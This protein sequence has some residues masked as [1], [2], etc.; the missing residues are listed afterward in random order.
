MSRWCCEKGM[1]GNGN[2]EVARKGQS[3]LLLQL[4]RFNCRTSATSLHHGLCSSM[5]RLPVTCS[6]IWSD[7]LD[8]EVVFDH[9]A[10]H[11]AAVTS[12]VVLE[13]AMEIDLAEQV[14]EQTVVEA[15]LGSMMEFAKGSNT[16]LRM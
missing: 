9:T 6:T 3:G 8:W 15:H 11:S 5:T 13:F 10:D 14:V 7:S 16:S 12:P 1:F 4:V 2:E